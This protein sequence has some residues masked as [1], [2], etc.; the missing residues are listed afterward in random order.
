MFEIHEVPDKNIRAVYDQLAV[1]LA[2]NFDTCYPLL[3]KSVVKLSK[4]LTP[5]QKT[6]ILKILEGA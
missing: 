3:F 6:A 1:Q 4:R 2:G 5:A